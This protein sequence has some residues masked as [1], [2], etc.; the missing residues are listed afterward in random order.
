MSD[1]LTKTIALQL[2]LRRKAKG[3]SLDM[4][5]QASGVSKAMLG[6]IERQESSPTVSTLW[7]IATGLAC[8]FSDLIEDGEQ[9][10]SH[11]GSTQGHSDAHFSV[12]TL[13]KYHPVTRMEMFELTIQDHHCQWSE[14][15][16]DGVFEHI[17]VV[18]GGLKLFFDDQ[19]HEMTAGDSCRFEANQRHAYEDLTGHSCFTDVICYTR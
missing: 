8:S 15:H 10:S 14:P 2:K 11:Y 16:S 19:W 6:Q 3:W 9:S 17:H 7:K 1:K 5:A 12:K 13:F 4:L 18:S